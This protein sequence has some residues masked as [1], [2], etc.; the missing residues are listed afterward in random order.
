MKKNLTREEV[1]GMLSVLPLSDEAYEGVLG[2]LIS[3][4]MLIARDYPGIDL[5]Q[6]TKHFNTIADYWNE[7]DSNEFIISKGFMED[8]KIWDL[9]HEQV[10]NLADCGC[11]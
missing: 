4:L 6:F 8:N 3:L 7:Q 5:E 11:L 2:L 10:E 1:I 9:V